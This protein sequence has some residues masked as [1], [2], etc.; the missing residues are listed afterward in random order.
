MKISFKKRHIVS[1][2][3]S[4]ISIQRTPSH[5]RERGDSDNGDPNR[6]NGRDSKRCDQLVAPED[7]HPEQSDAVGRSK[8]FE[9]LFTGEFQT[10]ST[11]EHL[12]AWNPTCRQHRKGQRGEPIG[13]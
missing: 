5:D 1:V 12:A 4:N 3:N 9:T 2:M 13:K 7:C 10:S 6:K 11:W 8:I